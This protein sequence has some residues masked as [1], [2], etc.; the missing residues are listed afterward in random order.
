MS[1]SLRRALEDELAASPEDLATHAAYADLLDEMDD[2]R[3][4]LIQ[5]QMALED[6]SLDGAARAEL[7][8]REAELLRTHR[9][10]VLGRLAAF[11]DRRGVSYEL[12]R[13]WLDELE[14][15]RLM[16]PFA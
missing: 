16:L 5:I 3:G 14:V 2:P 9:D 11:L 15:G 1:A 10:R 12:R 4:E 13:G 8:R 6:A 7:K